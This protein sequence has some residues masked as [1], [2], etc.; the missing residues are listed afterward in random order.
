VRWGYS[1]VGR[2]NGSQSLGQGF[3]SP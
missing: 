3:E 2:A 1:S